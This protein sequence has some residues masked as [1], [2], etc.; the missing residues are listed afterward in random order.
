[1]TISFDIKDMAS[2]DDLGKLQM[3]AYVLE[4]VSTVSV[5]ETVVV[6]LSKQS[7]NIR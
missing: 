1:M 4:K 3:S 6:I 2:Y 7:I 5:P